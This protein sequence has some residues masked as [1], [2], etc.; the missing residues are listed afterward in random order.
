MWARTMRGSRRWVIQNLGEL[1]GRSRYLEFC[2]NSAG[3][4]ANRTWTGR[5]NSTKGGFGSGRFLAN[6][7]ENLRTL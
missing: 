7:M 4:P 6:D 2:P 3:S 5:P 1:A